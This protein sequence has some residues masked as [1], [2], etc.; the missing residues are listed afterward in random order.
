MFTPVPPVCPAEAIVVNGIREPTEASIVVFRIL[1]RL[2]R[3]MRA[4][5]EAHVVIDLVVPQD[6]IRANMIVEK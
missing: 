3:V 1:G 4:A 5:D 6:S 2:F